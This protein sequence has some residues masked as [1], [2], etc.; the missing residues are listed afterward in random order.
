MAF[1]HGKNS[2][3][4]VDDS[5]GTLRNLSTYLDN[6]SG[7]PGGRE[8]ADVTVMGDG[9]HKFIPGLQNGEFSISG[10]YDPTTTTGPQA[11][12]AGIA[13]SSTATSSFE[14]GP[15]GNSTGNV[16]LS[17]ECWCEKYEITSSATE[18]VSFTAS[19]K[20]DGTVTVGTF[21]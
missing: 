17:G 13:L 1:V 6:V 7:L 4:L 15:E 2:K 12:L 11:V 18:K 3:F 21:A 20:I 14:Y 9:G 8:L 19:F 16:K 5:G 10:H